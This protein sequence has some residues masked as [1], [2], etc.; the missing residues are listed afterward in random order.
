M[1]MIHGFLSGAEKVVEL[2]T[3]MSKLHVRPAVW[4]RLPI[5]AFCNFRKEYLCRKSISYD[6]VV[7]PERKRLLQCH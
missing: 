4:Y 3:Y 5:Y 7:L 1:L 6:I 2:L